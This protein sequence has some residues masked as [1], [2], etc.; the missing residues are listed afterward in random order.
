[1]L[2]R[3]AAASDVEVTPERAGPG[4][5]PVL[6]SWSKLTEAGH[7]GGWGSTNPIRADHSENHVL[8]K[9]NAMALSGIDSDNASLS[10]D[11]F[12]QARPKSV[13]SGCNERRLAGQIVHIIRASK[14]G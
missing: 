9:V 11:H 13:A 10:S 5:A 14:D 3:H 6:G 1:V 4:V 7:A 2:P 12:E 8:A